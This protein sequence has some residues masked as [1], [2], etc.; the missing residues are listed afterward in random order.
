MGRF[1]S[2]SFGLLVMFLSLSG[3]GAKQD[4]LSDWSFYEGY[5]YKVFNEKKTWEDAEKFCTEQHKGSHLL[6]LHNIAEAD[7]VLKKTLAM[8]K[9]GVIWM[10]LNDVWNECNW[11]WTDGAKLD[12]KAWNEGTNCFVFKIAKNHWSHMDCSSTHNF[13]CKFRV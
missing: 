4:C 7:F 9:D 6:S 10:G 1:I 3:T 2:I 13:V 11:G 12:Y 5:C 8:L